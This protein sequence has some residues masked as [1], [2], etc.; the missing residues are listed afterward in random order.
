M[1]MSWQPYRL[2]S[3]AEYVLWRQFAQKPA[4]PIRLGRTIAGIEKY[5][6]T[7]FQNRVTQFLNREL[8]VR[9][10]QRIQAMQRNCVL[11]DSSSQHSIYMYIAD[12]LRLAQFQAAYGNAYSSSSSLSSAA[13]NKR[14][15]QFADLLAGMYERD[16]YYCLQDLLTAAYDFRKRRRHIKNRADYE[17]DDDSSNTKLD[18]VLLSRLGTRILMGHYLALREP[19]VEGLRGIIGLQLDL[20][21]I[22]KIA[23]DD[24]SFLFRRQYGPDRPKVVVDI[25]ESTS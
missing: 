13:S 22:L 7:T 23:I 24:A 10:A 14:T 6:P 12:F 16:A 5:G 2:M 3:G 1:T 11:F 9:L 18:D 17:L 15:R 8:M 4:T 21:Q 25:Q 20:E 19:T